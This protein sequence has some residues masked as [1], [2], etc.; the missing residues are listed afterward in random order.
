MGSGN[1]K[2]APKT[3]NQDQLS[4]LQLSSDKMPCRACD[5]QFT[6]F[7]HKHKCIDCQKLFCA[8]CINKN[9]RD[10]KICLVCEA[11]KR[12]MAR[13]ALMQLKIRELQQFLTVR[14]VSMES[15]TE[16]TDLVDLLLEYLINKGVIPRPVPLQSRPLVGQRVSATSNRG[17]TSMNA[18]NPVSQGNAL[19]SNIPENS[20]NT[21]RFN[22]DFDTLESTQQEEN[23]E[24]Y[25]EETQRHFNITTPKITTKKP[26]TTPTT[27]SAPS[28]TAT[29]SEADKR[30][31]LERRRQQ[32]M[33]EAE[34]RNI[35]ENP[36]PTVDPRPK[37]KRASIGDVNS[38]EDI[39]ELSV[40]ALKEILATNFVDYR[41]CVEKQEL[42]DRVKRLYKSKEKPND[43]QNEDDENLCKICMDAGIDC[44]LLECGHMVTC[45]KCGKVLAECPICRVFITRVVHTFKS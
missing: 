40:R 16:K 13:P 31:R 21:G 35:H 29:E 14:N 39:N 4:D 28:S 10:K 33:R 6:L 9:I 17:S 42:V 20:R 25:L 12:D 34:A 38:I 7:R 1:V 11:V 18:S 8:N 24:E 36:L 43:P 23:E 32:E 41:G 37:K 44:V 45:T 5:L 22:N 3:H 26:I 2:P 27:E 19:H 15:C 30:E